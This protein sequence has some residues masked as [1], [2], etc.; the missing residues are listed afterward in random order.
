MTLGPLVREIGVMTFLVDGQQVEVVGGAVHGGR[1]VVR[2]SRRDRAHSPTSSGGR[3]AARSVPSPDGSP[4][5]HSPRRPRDCDRSLGVAAIPG[6]GAADD[7]LAYA[8]YTSAATWSH[9]KADDGCEHARPWCPSVRARRN[10]SSLE[11]GP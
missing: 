8:R 6:E 5:G 3:R 7:V 11:V 1:A 9:T 10:C 2:R 4:V